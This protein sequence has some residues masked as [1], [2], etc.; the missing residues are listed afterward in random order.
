MKCKKNYQ[1]NQS[2]F[3]FIPITEN[4]N[5][6][7]RLKKQKFLPEIIK[8]PENIQ[9]LSIQELLNIFKFKKNQKEIIN[10]L[11]FITLKANKDKNYLKL[12]KNWEI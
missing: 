11:I 2:V 5:R 7:K 3:F 4:I 12:L 9:V 1:T 8:F 6:I 10:R